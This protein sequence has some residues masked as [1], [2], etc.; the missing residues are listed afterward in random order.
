M[1]ANIL[2]FE[3]N[4]P[5]IVDFQQFVED[6][7][8]P[9]LKERTQTAVLL[10]F[11]FIKILFVSVAKAGYTTLRYS[12]TA[13]K[14]LVLGS[15]SDF[16]LRVDLHLVAFKIVYWVGAV[17]FTFI[18]TSF[19]LIAQNL[20][21]PSAN[22]SLLTQYASKELDL[23]HIVT[24]EETIDMSG[25]PQ[26]VSIDHLLDMYD[27]IN[28]DRP[29]EPGYMAPASRSEGRT[30][31]TKEDL[32]TALETYVQY[33][34]NRT[35]FLGTPPA[36]DT[37]RLM[38]FY[39]QIEDA[40]RFAMHKVEQDLKDFY[41][42][43]VED[44]VKHANLLENKA[45]I[46]L[47]LAFA[48]KHCGG[49]YMGESMELYQAA[50]GK[51]IFTG[52]LQDALNELLAA[53]RM[54]IAHGEIQQ[55]LGNNTHSYANYL[56]TLGPILALPGT[57]NV[58]EH[59]ERP[60]NQNLYLQSFFQRYTVDF[61][62][63]SIQEG[64]RTSQSL[65][66]KITDWIG[67]QGE[68]WDQETIQKRAEDVLAQAKTILARQELNPNFSIYRAFLD[69]QMLLSDLQRQ[70]IE[71]PQTQGEDFFVELL[72]SEQA[73]TWLEGKSANI[74][75]RARR[76]QAMMILSNEEQL[77]ASLIQKIRERSLK[78]DDFSARILILDKTS[79]IRSIA[80]EIETPSILRAI[81]GKV[82]FEDILFNQLTVAKRSEFLEAL[83]L[84]IIQKE[85]LP[86]EL[87]E[88]LCV[89]QKIF[90]P[91]QAGKA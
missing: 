18:A 56:A 61:I 25:V 90:L 52:T 44:P 35:A 76:K 62:I 65:R 41:A 54:E 36:Y 14:H 71:L 68:S 42:S 4:P 16:R 30:S 39:Q 72:N 20:K 45:R 51:T 27:A 67:V 53:K 77:G 66:E 13:F 89:S 88:W 1:A 31:Y 48:G 87:L 28:F 19:R 70:G 26:D 29:N 17:A 9:S 38:A 2:R 81:E 91:Q 22:V 12:G 57:Q 58:I 64:V 60:L 55:H 21:D 47:M 75:E 59:L 46:P 63:D 15:W 8:E 80:P 37:P 74:I 43:G 85:G 7:K 33:V 82:K 3:I 50:K 49:R 79:K 34:K 69:L 24:K 6:K 40:T 11:Q 83:K 78:I 84:N 86:P 23:S 5:F 10:P 73:K 32:R